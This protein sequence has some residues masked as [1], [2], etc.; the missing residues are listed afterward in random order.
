MKKRQAKKII[1]QYYGWGRNDNRINLYWKYRWCKYDEDL[2][3]YRKRD[4]RITKA[5]KICKDLRKEMCLIID[6]TNSRYRN[7]W[8][9]YVL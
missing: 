8:D 9:R 6:K 4:H 1:F 2:P 7:R 3:E 5:L